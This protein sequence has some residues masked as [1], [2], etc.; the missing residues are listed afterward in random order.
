MAYLS[1]IL[2]ILTE[3]KKIYKD[4]KFHNCFYYNKKI[5]FNDLKK[6]ASKL[7][8]LRNVIMHFNIANYKINKSIYIDTLIYWE[9]LI[10]CKNCFIHSLPPIKP[11]I[12]NIL[13]QLKERYPD[14]YNNDDRYLCDVFDDIALK[15]NLPVEKLPQYW[16]IGR[17]IYKIKKSMI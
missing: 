14:I 16:S 10:Y 6:Y 15:N 13:N 1:D 7:K 4:V 11:T 5:N 9:M 12:N 8:K 2:K 17:Q 3:Y